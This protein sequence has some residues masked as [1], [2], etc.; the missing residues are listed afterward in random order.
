MS[1]SKVPLG[2]KEQFY[3]ADPVQRNSAGDLAD[4]KPWVTMPLSWKDL[5]C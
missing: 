2:Y 4:G 3:A 5:P 1:R